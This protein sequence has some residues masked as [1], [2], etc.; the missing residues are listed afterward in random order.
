M[1]YGTIFDLHIQMSTATVAVAKVRTA[2][3]M[4]SLSTKSTTALTK[5][6]S[7]VHS[8]QT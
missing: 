3:S 6:R 8:M 7:N 4:P 2:T 1:Q 5:E